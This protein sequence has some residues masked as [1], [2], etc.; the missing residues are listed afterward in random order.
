MNQQFKASCCIFQVDFSPQKLIQNK[1]NTWKWHKT[2]FASRLTCY[3]LEST[4][5]V[6]V[7]K[8]AKM[9]ILAM[10]SKSTSG[11][12]H[13]ASY[14]YM[15][16]L[17]WPYLNHHHESFVT[18]YTFLLV[19]LNRFY[20]KPHRNLNNLCIYNDISGTNMHITNW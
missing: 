2:I 1:T 4:R 8:K 10:Q 11:A 3:F 19:I 14:M 9:A 16:R 17:L 7:A 12:M 15:T 6:L 18:F 5:Y 20:N 13:V